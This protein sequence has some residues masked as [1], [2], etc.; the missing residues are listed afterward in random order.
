MAS[1]KTQP[2]SGVNAVAPGKTGLLTERQREFCRHYVELP[3]ATAAARAVGVPDSDH[4][5]AYKWLAM[6]DIQA[7]IA[8]LWQAKKA[9]AI[10]TA[11]EVIRELK[12]MAIL[13]PI[14]LFEPG[15]H[16]LRKL[17]DMPESTRRAIAMIETEEIFSGTG[18]E[19]KLIGHLKKIKLESKLGAANTLAKHLQLLVDKTPA[20]TTTPGA[21]DVG[22]LVD[23][24]A[25]INAILLAVK[26]RLGRDKAI[27]VT[28]VAG[29]DGEELI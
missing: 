25:K 29:L 19:R 3:D 8:D 26:D 27:D 23:V 7:Y 16:V 15:T 1:R 12:C 21:V 28:P 11:E 10:V 18:D 2:C 20:D 22:D 13:D 5:R 24:A 14:T 4:S 17:E 9:I 6:P